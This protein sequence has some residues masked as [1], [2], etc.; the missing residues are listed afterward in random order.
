MYEIPTVTQ[1]DLMTFL[2][3]ANET[4]GTEFTSISEH[5]GRSGTNLSPYREDLED[6]EV[7][8]KIDTNGNIY[9]CIAV[10]GTF[11]LS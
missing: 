6:D 2:A 3:I 8:F 1:N 7:W 4:L 10:C 11:L 5:Q 9:V